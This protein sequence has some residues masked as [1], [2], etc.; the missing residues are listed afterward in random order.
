MKFTK[1]RKVVTLPHNMWN[2]ELK[3]YVMF[4]RIC[5]KSTAGAIKSE[6]YYRGSSPFND[7][8]EPHEFD[9]NEKRWPTY[10]FPVPCDCHGLTNM[11][12]GKDNYIYLFH[13]G[14]VFVKKA[15][16]NA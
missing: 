1:S 5:S 7:P 3:N 6:W 8:H 16:S 13:N 2:G 10:C 12:Y 14:Q 9:D 15:K 11:M 4:G